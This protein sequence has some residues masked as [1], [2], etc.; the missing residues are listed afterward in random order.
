MKNQNVISD[1]NVVSMYKQILSKPNVSEETKSQIVIGLNQII[2]S[3]LN[4]PS[5]IRIECE[6][7]LNN[8]KK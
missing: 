5:S 7:L 8:I 3:K 2:K 4:T 1:E 6:N